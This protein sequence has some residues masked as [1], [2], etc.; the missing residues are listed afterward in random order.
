M[1]VVQIVNYKQD[2]W[3]PKC[4]ESL[5]ASDQISIF[6]INNSEIE[7]QTRLYLS[8]QPNTIIIQNQNNIGFSRALN[9][10]LEKAKG[11]YVLV[12]NPDTYLTAD[13][14]SILLQSME[15]DPD[16]GMVCGK[17]LRC[18]EEGQPTTV[19]DSTGMMIKRNRRELS[20][21]QDE[22]DTGQYDQP[23]FVFGCSGAVVLYR[24]E[25]LQDIQV[26]GEYFDNDFFIYK[27]HSCNV[28]Q[29]GLKKQVPRDRI[30]KCN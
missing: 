13:Y 9:M 16:I 20:R 14:L 5:P 15:K 3:L 11:K 30:E 19:I 12:L 21:G 27:E 22:I 8:S 6:V 10:G 17:L 26:T 24:W 23:E 1:I 25:M 4:I 18:T 7:E 28:L 29:G 2:H